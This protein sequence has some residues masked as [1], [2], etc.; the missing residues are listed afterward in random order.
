VSESEQEQEQVEKKVA[1]AIVA[2][3][4]DAEFGCAGTVAKW[5]NE[6]WDVYYVLCTDGGSGGPDEATEITPE[7]RQQG[8][9]LREQEQRAAAEILGVKDVIFLGYPDG[10][11]QPNLALRRDLVRLLRTYRPTRV[12][13]Q[14]PDRNWEGQLR[15]PAYHPDHLAAG[16]AA[17][18]A[19]YP[20]SQN[21]W[22]FVE[23]FNDEGLRPHKV[24]EIYI[25]MAPVLNHGVNISST[26]EQKRNALL[27]HKSQLGEPSVEMQQFLQEWSTGIGKKYGFEHGEEFHLTENR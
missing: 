26:I 11:L 10:E 15:I 14:S 16:Q 12:I 8:I 18:S 13:C 22:D 4:D 6:G 1:M 7:A 21:P 3:P 9:T 17:L 25:M 24:S 27:A 5:A 20:A 19:I 2:H 23:L